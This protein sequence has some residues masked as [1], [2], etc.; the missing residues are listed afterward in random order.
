MS[1]QQDRS[2]AGDA[3]L[4][5]RIKSLEKELRVLKRSAERPKAS[6]A[7]AFGMPP[8]PTPTALPAAAPMMLAWLMSW[9]FSAPQSNP[10]ML[11]SMARFAA[12]R[13]EFWHHSFEALAAMAH[14]AA[15]ASQSNALGG[16]QVSPEDKIKVKAALEERKLPPNIIDSVLHAMN[17]LDA[18]QSYREAAMAKHQS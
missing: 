8:P 9:L 15:Q 3:E 6:F 7:G 2:A 14:Q 1:E 17:A 5:K 4:L 11:D 10:A 16:V 18:F 12:A 13:G